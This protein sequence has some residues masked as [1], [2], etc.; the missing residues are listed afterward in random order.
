MNKLLVICGPTATGK[1]RVAFDLAKKFNGELISADSRMVYKYMDIGTG[2]DL[3]VNLK[4]QNL[5][6]KIH[7]YDLVRSDEEFSVSQ[8]ALFANKA[9]TEI[10]N[11]KKLPILVGGSGFYIKA[12]IDGIETA[13]IKPN[14]R[15]TEDL[16]SK[17]AD[18][19]FK[20]LEDIDRFRAE[21][22]NESDKRNPRRLI[23]AIEISKACPFGIAKSNLKFK[24]RN[25]KSNYIVLMIGL[26]CDLE[27]LKKRIGKRV[28]ESA[29]KL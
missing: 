26:T 11:R 8:Y 12:V 14:K 3:P 2:K 23:R 20:M 25:L 17:T 6:V 19:L 18:E 7:G 1:T 15:L 4:S 21:K 24:I 29:Q 10:F 5:N 9:I 28:D 13:D 27:E 16:Q 22:M